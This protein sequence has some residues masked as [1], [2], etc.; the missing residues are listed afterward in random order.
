LQSGFTD[1]I[2]QLVEVVDFRQGYPGRYEH[3]ENVLRVLHRAALLRPHIST[4][5][6]LPLKE[7]SFHTKD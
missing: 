1:E 7:K 2:E 4:S 3:R 5:E 6:A